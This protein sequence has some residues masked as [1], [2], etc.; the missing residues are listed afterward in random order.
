M[1]C[2]LYIGILTYTNAT[3]TIVLVTRR[4]YWPLYE[5]H[6]LAV[7]ICVLAYYSDYYFIADKILSRG[8]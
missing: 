3:I 4:Y 5:A 7:T 6:A 1:L 2:T 8:S